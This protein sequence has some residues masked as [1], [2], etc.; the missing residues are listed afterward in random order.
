MG[1]KEG[2]W[3]DEHRV[4]YTTDELLKTTSETNDELYVG[5][6]NLNKNKKQLES[7]CLPHW[8][9]S[10]QYKQATFWI[11][12]SESIIFAVNSQYDAFG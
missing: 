9:A 7:E 11:N 12:M 1:I 5:N 8:V 4:L 3:R 10:K 6:L 2:T